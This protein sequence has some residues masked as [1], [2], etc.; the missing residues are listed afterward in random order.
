MKIFWVLSG[1]VQVLAKTKA[2]PV[3]RCSQ[4]LRLF[5]SAVGKRISFAQEETQTVATHREELGQYAGAAGKT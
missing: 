1:A 4:G 5:N 2:T 3:C